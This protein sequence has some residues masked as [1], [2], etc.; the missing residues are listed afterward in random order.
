VNV[1]DVQ[2][3]ITARER[4]LWEHLRPA[5]YHLWHLPADFVPL[6]LGWIFGD[7]QAPETLAGHLREIGSRRRRPED[8]PDVDGNERFLELWRMARRGEID[9]AE[10]I[11]LGQLDASLQDW[12]PPEEGATPVPRWL[13][14]LGSR[15]LTA[16]S[17]RPEGAPEDPVPELAWLGSLAGDPDLW[18]DF[19]FHRSP[20]VLPGE[21]A[22]AI[23]HDLLLG[24]DDLRELLAEHRTAIE[25]AWTRWDAV[26]RSSFLWLLNRE[27]LLEPFEALYLDALVTPARGLQA[28]VLERT[29]EL[30][31]AQ[32][33]QTLSEALEGADPETRLASADVL[34]WVLGE[35]ARALLEGR[36][37]REPDPEVARRIRWALHLLDARCAD[38]APA[39]PAFAPPELD[40]RFAPEFAT[41]L[42]LENERRLRADESLRTRWAH[43][44]VISEPEIREQLAHLEGQGPPLERPHPFGI[45]AL[46]R[47]P[48]VDLVHLARSASDWPRRR[49]GARP[50][51]IGS[52]PVAFGDWFAF[53]PSAQADLRQ[54][55]SVA[56]HLDWDAMT[57]ETTILDDREARPRLLASI[58]S[59]G[60]WPWFAEHP[61]VLWRRIV[62]DPSERRDA[63]DW[64]IVLD[65]LEH[66]PTVLAE[67]RGP[68]FD[69]ALGTLATHRSRAQ[70]VLARTREAV[71]LA[72]AQLAQATGKAER[73]VAA[74]WLGDLGDASS[75]PCLF[76]EARREKREDVLATLLDSIRRLG[77]DLGEL[78]T[79]EVLSAEAVRALK[80][81]P[82]AAIAWFPFASLPEDL[83]WRH[84]GG[85]VPPEVPRWWVTLA[86][87]LKDPGNTLL[88]AYLDMLEPESAA[89]LGRSVLERFLAED[90]RTPNDLE[91]EEWVRKELPKVVG[92]LRYL[93]VHPQLDVIRRNL[94]RE[95]ADRPVG[96]AMSAKGILA[97]CARSRWSDVEPLV[98]RF[99]RDH[100]ARWKQVAA[101]VE[102]FGATED[103]AAIQWLLRLASGYRTKPVRERAVELVTAIGAR[104]GWSP[105]QLADRTLP[106][107]GFDERGRIELSFGPRSFRLVLDE[108]CALRIT[109]ASDQP[110]RQLPAPRK[111]DDEDAVKEAKA[112]LKE[113]R[114]ELKAVVQGTTERLYEAMCA[115]RSWTGEEWRT[116]LLEHPIAGRLAARLLWEREDGT[117]LRPVAGGVDALPAGAVLRLAHGSRLDART[118]ESWQEQLRSE[119]VEPLFEQLERTAIEGRFR[120]GESAITAF[121]GYLTDALR[122]KGVMTRLG[123]RR[124]EAEDAG[125]F[126][127]YRR[128]YRFVPL[129][130]VLHFTGSYLPET[131]MTVAL[132]EFEFVR[133]DRGVETPVDLA[134]VPPVLLS[135]AM[136]QLE[137]VAAATDG[138]VP[139]WEARVDG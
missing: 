100:Y 21:I 102:G 97:L 122:L 35:E 125:M 118:R 17:A 106:T 126:H 115:E 113:V 121:R 28:R 9:A 65:V 92:G 60:I 129:A 107:A 95:L 88:L 117:L 83:K 69:L 94:R 74:R 78:L 53:H 40:A 6:A 111:D 41:T 132:K 57:V 138:Y 124:S 96:S 73:L 90:L 58:P 23:A 22:E 39:P 93:R 87:K 25:Q 7:P 108:R 89:R 15:Y 64:E 13:F 51:R 104:H 14:Q 30:D 66:F 112:R 91:L 3:L 79:P 16:R 43:R 72:A 85:V 123:Y 20:R 46:S 131:K 127:R 75:I 4:R 10:W 8:G 26:A 81:K 135:E 45:F 109:D 5:F 62:A 137:G 103:P 71:S 98:Q 68:L 56:D 133:T 27:R 36:S 31:G 116:Y 50:S 119:S 32:V 1:N 80:K 37:G 54:L 44:H 63:P 84:G 70:R 130:A 29:G 49:G 48:E 12:R 105:E 19:V 110:L 55:Q 67:L 42:Y 34:P 47:R 139:D 136:A 52:C 76:D 120:P 18:L 2:R 77:G 99:L 114:R 82:P 33:A 61:L 24:R 101:I 38:P 59:D 11:R 134:D 86:A 128:P